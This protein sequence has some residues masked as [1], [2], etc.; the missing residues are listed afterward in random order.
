MG[1]KELAELKS[2]FNT[3]KAQ[4]D[5]EKRS[6]EGLSKLRE[7]IDEVNNQIQIAQREGNLEK[8]AELKFCCL[9]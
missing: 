1:E 2:D 7:Q 5:N 3:Q 4:W 6:V 8:A 9:L